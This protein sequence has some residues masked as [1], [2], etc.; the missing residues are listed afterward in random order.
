MSQA[1]TQA[2]STEPQANPI[3]DRPVVIRKEYL[4]VKDICTIM[5][6][7]KSHGYDLMREFYEKRKA[8]KDGRSFRVHASYFNEWRDQRDGSLTRFAQPLKV[9]KGGQI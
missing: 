6:W 7:P 1:Q 2:K 4:S 3:Y 5:S 8:I 9:I